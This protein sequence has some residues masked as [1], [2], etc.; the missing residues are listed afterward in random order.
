MNQT[1]GIQNYPGQFQPA[2]TQA[3]P[4]Q[5]VLTSQGQ[6]VQYYIQPG[7]QVQPVQT[8]GQ[9]VRLVHTG[10]PQIQ[11]KQTTPLTTTYWK[12]ALDAD[13]LIEFV[14]ILFSVFHVT[15]SSHIPRS[16]VSMWTKCH[17]S[18]HQSLVTTG[19]NFYKQQSAD[20]DSLVQRHSVT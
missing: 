19:T 5:P 3:P 13:R 6:P 10:Q 9:Q 18:K 20:H 7:Q 11:G 8:A 16:V 14:S 12:S 17:F 4:G 1:P 2:F 15:P